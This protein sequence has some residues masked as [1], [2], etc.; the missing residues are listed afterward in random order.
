MT[1]FLI[2]FWDVRGMIRL[3]TNDDDSI[4]TTHRS[5]RKL[6][7]P[8]YSDIPPPPPLDNSFQHQELAV[9]EVTIGEESDEETEF[10]KNSIFNYKHH[11]NPNEK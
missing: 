1:Q 10:E 4:S 7:I 6:Q 5:Q 2:F 8:P 3:S 9:S 11:Y